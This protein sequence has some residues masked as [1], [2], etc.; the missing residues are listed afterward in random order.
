MISPILNFYLERICLPGYQEVC[1][2]VRR[3]FIWRKVLSYL[4]FAVTW[5]ALLMLFAHSGSGATAMELNA[6]TPLELTI[7]FGALLLSALTLD[8]VNQGVSI[9][10]DVALSN[11][12]ATYALVSAPAILFFVWTA[13][14]SPTGFDDEAQLMAAYVGFALIFTPLI[15]SGTG[16]VIVMVC[17][18]ALMFGYPLERILI[19]LQAR[20]FSSWLLR[21]H[22]QWRSS[23]GKSLV[24]VGN[25]PRVTDLSKRIFVASP[26]LRTDEDPDA[27][28]IVLLTGSELTDREKVF[29]AYQESTRC[30]KLDGARSDGLSGL[31]VLGAA[32][33]TYAAYDSIGDAGFAPQA[34]N[35]A[36]GLPTIGGA[37]HIDV[38]GNAWGTND[39]SF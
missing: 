11:P 21:E 10:T 23:D 20:A 19:A 30:L 8:L 29:A 17:S 33:A 39:Q 13:V 2:K 35:P 31:L 12:F 32:G 38:A 26:I 22:P 4:A 3:Q 14:A 5:Q 28:G 25:K 6:L 18:A 7:G 16:L 27:L 36:S 24:N 1:K 37:G 9:L 34:I 15:I